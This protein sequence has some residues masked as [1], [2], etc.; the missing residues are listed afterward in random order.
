MTPERGYSVDPVVVGTRWDGQLN[1]LPD[2]PDQA[3]AGLS[4]ECILNQLAEALFVDGPLQGR[5][6]LAT[7]VEV[8][9]RGVPLS[10][11]TP[12]RI[13]CIVRTVRADELGSLAD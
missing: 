12:V 3:E 2:C 11:G 9:R 1:L 4:A 10:L 7:Q 5:L 13:A 8:V 6:C